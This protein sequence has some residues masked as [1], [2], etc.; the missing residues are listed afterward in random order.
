MQI[1]SVTARTPPRVEGPSPSSRAATACRQSRSQLSRHDRGTLRPVTMLPFSGPLSP[2]TAALLAPV[3]TSPP[4]AASLHPTPSSARCTSPRVSVATLPP[5]SLH[6]QCRAR[7]IR[8]P[9]ARPRPGNGPRSSAR[10]TSF[11]ERYKP[12]A[13]AVALYSLP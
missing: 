3:P 4:A 6:L 9:R 11:L 8:A 5:A 7:L 13:P 2:G 12:A 10:H 1:A